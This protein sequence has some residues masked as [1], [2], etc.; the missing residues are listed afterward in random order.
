MTIPA[1]L[2]PGMVAISNRCAER[3]SAGLSPKPA[4]GALQVMP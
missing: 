1:L 3:M 4:V 2:S